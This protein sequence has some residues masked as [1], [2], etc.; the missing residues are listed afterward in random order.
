ME[1]GNSFY[2]LL[3]E[4]FRRKKSADVE[5]S[6]KDTILKNVKSF[7]KHLIKLNISKAIETITII[8]Y[9]LE[10]GGCPE[11][12]DMTQADFDLILLINAVIL[13]CG[14]KWDEAEELFYELT[15]KYQ[16]SLFFALLGVVKNKRHIFRCS[17][18]AFCLAQITSHTPKVFKN[19]NLSITNLN[20][21]KL[22]DSIMKFL[23]YTKNMEEIP[24]NNYIKTNNI[25]EMNDV[26]T[27]GSIFR[28]DIFPI[29]RDQ[30]DMFLGGD[31]PNNNQVISNDKSTQ[32]VNVNTCTKG[33]QT[34]LVKTINK[35]VQT[36]KFK[37]KND[38]KK[39]KELSVLKT[40]VD[41][42]RKSNS[43][44]TKR[45]NETLS[46][47]KAAQNKINHLEDEIQESRENYIDHETTM[48]EIIQSAFTSLHHLQKT[49][50]EQTK[51]K[52]QSIDAMLTALR[53]DFIK[54][55]LKEDV[56]HL[57]W[58]IS[59]YQNEAEHYNKSI[60]KR[61]KQILRLLHSNQFVEILSTDYVLEPNLTEQPNLMLDL[62][63]KLIT[64]CRNNKRRNQNNPDFN[65]FQ[66]W[67]LQDEACG[68]GYYSNDLPQ[69]HREFNYLNDSFNEDLNENPDE[70]LNEECESFEPY[71][72]PSDEDFPPLCGLS[73]RKLKKIKARDEFDTFVTKIQSLLPLCTTTQINGAIKVVQSQKN[74]NF[75]EIKLEDVVEYLKLT[76]KSSI[77]DDATNNIL[78]FW[79]NDS[80]SDKNTQSEINACPICLDQIE[81]NEMPL[82]C[83][84]LFHNNCIMEWLRNN[85]SCPICRVTIPYNYLPF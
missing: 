6:Q 68:G 63:A 17:R 24:L 23:G 37:D 50:G 58:T 25:F 30:I 22:K 81:Q 20:E 16:E 39:D 11:E 47:L 78:R 13:C 2:D 36:L 29:I 76:F 59:H 55:D 52:L 56:D 48:L 1:S 51:Q 9:Y 74:V 35:S 73:R 18:D 3:K 19:L 72:E 40:T 34:D 43:D 83:G 31:L 69:P 15:E 27:I 44:L 67:A 79:E 49:T 33:F 46:N 57:S 8:R 26:K 84:H 82:S 28:D 10:K 12:F 41:E 85:G 54:L 14:R 61:H 62:I 21:I 80:Q 38:Q 53:S 7:I 75:K 42:L 45:L 77:I 4:E 5:I 60:D 66:G 64:I 65:F 71:I 70:T 32:T